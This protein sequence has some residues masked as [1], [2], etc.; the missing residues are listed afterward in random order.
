M[1]ESQ[2]TEWKE[3]W[4]DE[5]LKWVC[6]F[7]NSEGGVLLIGKSDQGAVKNVSNAR[8]LLEDLP[9]K[10]KNH[11]GI[12][13]E[14]KLKSEDAKKY[15]EI[16]VQAYTNPISYKGKYYV[17]SGSST[18]ALNGVELTEFLLKKSGQTWDAITAE[19]ASIADI[20]GKSIRDFIASSKSKNRLP[21]TDG[22]SDLEILEKLRLADDGKIKR[23]ALVLFGKD[24]NRFFA[25]CKIM[26]GRFG[27]D[28]EELIA[29][30][31]IEG[32]LIYL[33]RETQDLL[34]YKFLNRAVDFE[35]LHRKEEDEY[36]AAALREMLLNALV[37]KKYMGAAIQ[38]RVFENK[39]SI[40][41]EGKLPEGLSIDN[42]KEEHNSK[43]PNPLIADACF[44]AGYIDTWGRGTL[45]IYKA[46]A[47][48]RLPEP[49]IMEKNGGIEVT[50]FKAVAS[51][52]DRNDF[53]T[54]LEQ[55]RNNFG[56]SVEATFKVISE[57]PELTTEQISTI[58]G[59][60]VRSV[61]SYISRLK[62]ANFI[63]RVGPTIGGYWKIKEKD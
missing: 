17:R 61:K 43:P 26:I 9:A 18:H 44:K 38:I 7:A 49:Q 57:N 15:L 2:H 23:A 33:L 24:P 21:Q 53:G 63:E 28:S 42:L 60:S 10:I 29:H 39:L 13:C 5:Y 47:E 50:L 58:I 31:P 59:K 51:E 48:A 19:D 11:L 6:A 20:D 55:I 27:S 3:S 16:V 52:K 37:H 41:N 56:T 25:N 54:I 45:K 12:V 30:E 32:N 8:K 22:L 14:V 62:D 4:R 40:W 34:N 46:C 36:P 1:S 35:G